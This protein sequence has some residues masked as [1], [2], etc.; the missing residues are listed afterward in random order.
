MIEIRGLTKVYGE[1]K[2][3]DSLNLTIRKGEVFGLLGPNGAGKTTTTLMLLGLTEPTAGEAFI[4]ERDC[5]KEP[6]AVKRIVGYLP[7]N[8]G[9][10]SDL[11]GR[12]N[13]YFTGRL[14]GLSE[15]ELRERAEKLLVR[16]GMSEAADQKTGTYSRGMRQRLGIADVLMKDPEVIIMDEPT[17]GIDPQ[18]MRD[19]LRLIRE[20][21]EEDG[22]TVLVSSH[23]LYQIQQVCDRVGI[24]VEGRLI[25]C[26]TI[27]EL[28]KKM[29]REG[30]YTL[31]L[32]AEPDN[33]ALVSL[34]S[35][36]EG[37]S[38]VERE[39]ELLLVRSGED[40][41]RRATLLLAANGYT[42]LQL[43]QK[44]GD[45]DE[46]YSRYFE[47]A[48]AGERKASAGKDRK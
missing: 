26:G 20:L 21:A 33:D 39:G 25:A 7:D 48:E 4:A 9:F 45:L 6:I 19:L 36:M 41:R 3:V 46:I 44:G 23:Q 12:E 24:F 1:K 15:E 31:E 17:L 29:E 22:R 38:A 14:N 32:Q 42:V 28:G 43:R 13:L 2:A 27:G 37:A 40:I 8:V 18:G 11:T 16:V 30:K 35:H 5:T 34:L 10:Y 47:Q